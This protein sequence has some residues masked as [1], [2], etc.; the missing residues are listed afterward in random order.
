MITIRYRK[1]KTGKYS[2]YLDSW[3]TITNKH[4]YKFL[5]MQ[6]LR[7]YSKPF[8]LKDGTTSIGK[9]GA[10]KLMPIEKEDKETMALIENIKRKLELEIANSENGFA[11]KKKTNQSF[12]AYLNSFILNNND[13][14]GN[15]LKFNIGKFTN[16]NELMFD[17]IT[18]NWIEA[19]KRHLEKTLSQNSVRGYLSK[20]KQVLIHALKAGVIQT[21]NFHDIEIPANID[22]EIDPLTIDEVQTLVNSTVNFNIQIKQAFLFSCFTGLRQSDVMNLKWSNIDLNEGVIKI[23]PLKTSNRKRN[24]KNIQ[25]KILEA[26]LTESAKKILTEIE[27]KEGKDLVFFDLPARQVIGKHLMIWGLKLG[28]KK[29]IHFHLARHT[30]ATIGITYGID[31]YGMQKLLLHSKIE[32]TQRYAKIVEQKIKNDVSKFPTI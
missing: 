6:V 17:E 13:E 16:D 24:S 25:G 22:A 18:F 29:H 27:R 23:T 31:V 32:Q 7:D 5:K 26:P 8:F 15:R 9:N 4:E 2:V 1:L 14:T 28:L 20:L 30:F 21:H 19:F 3:N 11:K 10:I 12:T